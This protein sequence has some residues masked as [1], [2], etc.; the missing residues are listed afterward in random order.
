MTEL[1]E[2]VVK[3]AAEKIAV[4][5][6]ERAVAESVIRAGEGDDTLFAR[7][8]HG[9]FKRGFDGFKTR[10]TENDFSGGR[11][12]R[13]P[14]F[15]EPLVFGLVNSSF[16]NLPA[17]KSEAAQF[18]REFGLARWGCTSPIACGRRAICLCPAFTTR[19]LA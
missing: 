6:V 12:I 16:R 5:H 4:R 10:I 7:G 13:V 1:A 8:E 18:A 15:H 14:D 9:R 19:G 11:V 3:R 2:L 17:F